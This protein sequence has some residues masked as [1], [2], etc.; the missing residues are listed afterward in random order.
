[1]PACACTQIRLSAVQSKGPHC[2]GT[3]DD[4]MIRDYLFTCIVSENTTNESTMN[5]PQ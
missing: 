5:F 3:F 1:M 4:G 2:F